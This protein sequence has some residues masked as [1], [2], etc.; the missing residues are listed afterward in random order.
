MMCGGLSDVTE[1]D[2]EAEVQKICDIVSRTRIIVRL[3]LWSLKTI[4]PHLAAPLFYFWYRCLFIL[5]QMKPHAEQKAG[6]TYDVFTAKR[7]R[8]QV[9]AGKNY[10]IKVIIIYKANKSWKVII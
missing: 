3:W 10:F 7:Y 1:A 6:K 8:T 5:T 2:A 4:H 9:V